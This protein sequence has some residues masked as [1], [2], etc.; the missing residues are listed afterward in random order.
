MQWLSCFYNFCVD[1]NNV[2][3]I[4]V[5]DVDYHC[6]I[7]NISKSEVTDLLPKILCLKIVGIYKK[8]F[9]YFQSTQDINK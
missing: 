6:I 2:A 1:I 4:T 5:K 7:Q 8:Y 3:R 9:P